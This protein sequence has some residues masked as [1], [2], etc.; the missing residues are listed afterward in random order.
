M[1][2]VVTLYKIA[3]AMGMCARMAE[4]ARQTYLRSFT[5]DKMVDGYMRIYKRIC[6]E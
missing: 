2:T 4:A 3:A 6:G 5:V 1:P